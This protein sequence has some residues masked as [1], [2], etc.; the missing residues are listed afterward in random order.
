MQYFSQIEHIKP[1]N[2]IYRIQD[3]KE[4]VSISLITEVVKGPLARVDLWCTLQ[5][6]VHGF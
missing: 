4:K 5:R 2:T 6:L 1:S 3:T